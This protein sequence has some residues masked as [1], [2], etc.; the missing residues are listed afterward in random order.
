M[1]IISLYPS[2]PDM[3]SGKEYRG[4]DTFSTFNSG[5]QTSPQIESHSGDG[6]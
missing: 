3:I 1:E 5:K 2:D 4:G 6:K